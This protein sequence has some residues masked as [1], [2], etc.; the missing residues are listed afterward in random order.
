MNILNHE[1]FLL[2]CAKYYE[3]PNCYNVKEFLE[4]LKRIKYIK[5]L[6][7]RYLKGGELKERLI[8]NHIIILNNMFGAEHLVRILFLKL[9]KEHWPLVKPFLILLNVLP[10]KILGLEETIFTDDI[11]IDQKIVEILRKI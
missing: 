2:Y 9:D 11:A 6:F 8:L 1:N 7:T 3:N 5:K 10:A 4:D